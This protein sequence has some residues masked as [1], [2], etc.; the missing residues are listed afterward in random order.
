MIPYI[1]DRA[2]DR[3]LRREVLGRLRPEGRDRARRKDRAAELAGDLEHADEAVDVD[4]PGALG[5]GLGRRR[6]QGGQVKDRV[7]TM[8][9]HDLGQALAV[10]AVQ[11]V[12]RS[13]LDELALR[14]IANVGDHDVVDAAARPQGRGELRAELPEGSRDDDAL[15]INAS[16]VH[17]I[18]RPPRG[19][20]AGRGA[21]RPRLGGALYSLAEA[22]R[23]SGLTPGGGRLIVNL[24]SL[25]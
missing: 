20:R 22:R 9:P 24:R 14:V 11:L 19:A 16:S 5:I 25:Y 6:E 1:A 23:A 17:D 10:A 12:E 2:L 3:G 4:V 8:G 13:A 15:H 21:R 7:G 18:R